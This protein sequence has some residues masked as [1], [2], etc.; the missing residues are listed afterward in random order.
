L[1]HL[2]NEL[3]PETNIPEA[4]REAPSKLFFPSAPKT[5][6]PMTQTERDQFCKK[7]FQFVKDTAALE[8]M[9]T[10]HLPPGK[11]NRSIFEIAES[12][13][14]SKSDKTLRE[15]NQMIDEYIEG[16][17]ARRNIEQFDEGLINIY[18]SLGGL[19]R[20]G[21]TKKSKKLKKNRHSTSK[22]RRRTRR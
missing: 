1:A 2:E 19:S 18:R 8:L 9:E 4:P 22:K 14:R 13:I 21:R 11:R 15:V 12:K 7:I 3:F 6:L 20:G 10:Q 17:S 5:E 16:P